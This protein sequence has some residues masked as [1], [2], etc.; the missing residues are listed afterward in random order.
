M[1][2]AT[3][4]NYIVSSI[5]Q[6][7]AYTICVSVTTI[8]HS[9]I[10]LDFGNWVIHLFCYW[11]GKPIIALTSFYIIS[12]CINTD[13]MRDWDYL[14]TTIIGWSNIM[15][16]EKVLDQITFWPPDSPQRFWDFGTNRWLTFFLNHILKLKAEMWRSKIGYY[17]EIIKNMSNN[18]WVS[19]ATT[20]NKTIK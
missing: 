5:K 8:I 9:L 14:F 3:D 20:R 18:Y 15:L 4:R 16:C 6:H 7:I 1:N 13:S 10:N 2:L 17:E 19:V 12:C 11:K